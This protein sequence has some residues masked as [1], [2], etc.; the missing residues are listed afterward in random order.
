[1]NLFVRLKYKDI[2]IQIFQLEDNALEMYVRVWRQTSMYCLLMKVREHWFPESRCPIL[3]IVLIKTIFTMWRRNLELDLQCFSYLSIEFAFFDF[4]SFFYI[5]PIE[6]PR[7]WSW[8]DIPVKSHFSSFH[9]SSW[10]H[11]LQMR[12]LGFS[13]I[14]FPV[15]RICSRGFR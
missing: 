8:L 12:S 2:K 11:S 6:S 7:D 9:C 4:Q 3:T 15:W 1:M 5:F 13:Y 10:S 14:F